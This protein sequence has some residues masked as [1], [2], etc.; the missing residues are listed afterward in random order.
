MS[1]TLLGA[2]I[3][4]ISAIIG[5]ITIPFINSKIKRRNLVYQQN[6]TIAS[7]LYLLKNN[8]INLLNQQIFIDTL[9][10]SEAGKEEVDKL[11]KLNKQIN[12][13]I[14]SLYII[15]QKI[16]SNYKNENQIALVY[17]K[18]DELEHF[19]WSQKINFNYN[20]TIYD[21]ASSDEYSNQ[22]E[23]MII[24]FFIPKIES[25]IQINKSSTKVKLFSHRANNS[26]LSNEFHTE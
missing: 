21:Q 18:I 3:A 11:K 25:I 19:I 6:L 15:Q 16:I 26:P 22:L 17:S 13:H 14:E 23:N 2:L 8:L 24:K 20:K 9:G 4:I 7:I 12:G 1:Y 5:G 10:E